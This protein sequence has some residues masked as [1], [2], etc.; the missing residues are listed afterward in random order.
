MCKCERAS[1]EPSVREKSFNWKWLVVIDVKPDH[2]V[3]FVTRN[4]PRKKQRRQ[5]LFDMNVFLFV[6]SYLFF[7]VIFVS[8]FSKTNIGSTFSEG[9]TDDCCITVQWKFIYFTSSSASRSYECFV[10][11]FS[12]SFSF[13]FRVHL[14]KVS[15][16]SRKTWCRKSKHFTYIT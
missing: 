1:F 14:I 12:F 11:H 5:D 8:L 7:V 6:C 4:L 9:Y 2:N 15:Q 10:F 3:L 13:P 16:L